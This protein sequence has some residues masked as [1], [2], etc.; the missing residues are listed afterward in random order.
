MRRTK[1]SK[2]FVTKGSLRKES[3]RWLPW[4]TSNFAPDGLGDDKVLVTED[5]VAVFSEGP[6]RILTVSGGDQVMGVSQNMRVTGLEGPFGRRGFPVFMS[7]L[8]ETQQNLGSMNVS[9]VWYWWLRFK[10]QA[11]TF[12][13]SPSFTTSQMAPA[14]DADLQ[15]ILNRSDVLKW[16]MVPVFGPTPNLPWALNADDLT[17]PVASNVPTGAFSVTQQ[18]AGGSLVGSTSFS[19][20]AVTPRY[21][22][23]YAVVPF[24]RFPR[25]GLKLG[26]QEVLTCVMQKRTAFQG[27]DTFLQENPSNERS[28]WMMRVGR[29]RVVLAK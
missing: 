18:N 8:D 10:L 15:N 28:V 1:W 14:P 6:Q 4:T 9:E 23:R 27:T 13:G 26:T 22:G 7:A 17:L 12:G 2:R 25:G 24:P 29:T 3:T 21:G 11:Q 16:G 19:A 5:P 20:G